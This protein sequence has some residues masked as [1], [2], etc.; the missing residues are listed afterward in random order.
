VRMKSRARQATRGNQSI[1]QSIIYLHNKDI[2]MSS[3]HVRIT[4]NITVINNKNT[5]YNISE[6]IYEQ[7]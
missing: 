4:D 1:N 3:M 7:K 5:F 2:Y 6:T